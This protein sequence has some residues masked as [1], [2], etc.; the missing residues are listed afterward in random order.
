MEKYKLGKVMIIFLLL[1]AILSGCSMKKEE[2]NKQPENVE[3]SGTSEEVMAVGDMTDVENL[4]GW[5]NI[6][7][8]GEKLYYS[9]STWDKETKTST[10]QVYCNTGEGKADSLLMEI[11]KLKSLGTMA[12][13]EN[14]NVYLLYGIEEGFRIEKRAERGDIIYSVLAEGFLE[15]LQESTIVSMAVT[16]EGKLYTLTGLGKILVWNENGEELEAIQTDWSIWSSDAYKE[17]Y[18]GICAEKSGEVIAWWCDGEEIY[19]FEVEEGKITA[20][21]EI[22]FREKKEELIS[23]FADPSGIFLLVGREQLWRYDL[24]EEKLESVLKWSDREVSEQPDFIEEINSDK[25]GGYVLLT[26]DV[27]QNIGQRSNIKLTKK[28]EIPEGQEIVLGYVYGGDGKRALEDSI[29]KFQ[30]A[31]KEYYLTEQVYYGIEE[32]KTALARGEG[33]DILLLDNVMIDELV[34]KDI[35]EDLTPWFEQSQQLSVE[36]MLLGAIDAAYKDQGIRFVFPEFTLNVFVV[37]KGHVN[38]AGLKTLDFLHMADGRDGW[39]CNQGDT[40]TADTL[41]DIV[42]RADIEQYINWEEKT[43]SFD[44]EEFKELLEVVKN[45]KVPESEDYGNLGLSE[46]TVAECLTEGKYY[47]S[48]ENIFSIYDYYAV[49]EAFGGIADVI[50]YPNQKGEDIWYFNPT[51]TLGINSASGQKEGAWRFIEYVLLDRE[52]LN[53]FTELFSTVVPVLEEQLHRKADP[54]MLYQFSN[55]YTGE[56]EQKATELTEEQCDKLLEKMNQAQW[57][58][59]LEYIDFQRIIEEEAAYYFHGD[60]TVEDVTKVIQS[61]IEL[62]MNEN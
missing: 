60:K 52:S 43:C 11:S 30:R 55:R 24:K 57:K 37:E 20:K 61:R 16:K 50:G 26:Y 38:N 33:P 39:L 31:Q 58:S 9:V 22:P 21:G 10:M 40:L 14:G 2:V 42:L 1:V 28:E 27:F 41:L 17:H 51:V 46:Y 49:E 56:S 35:L 36:E 19:L 13:D 29:K 45:V 12:P 8:C 53:S 48:F 34:S 47:G 59:L 5:D 62:M 4:G 25:E 18:S 15:D 6:A 32:L 44:S 54:N 7:F 23:V 3:T